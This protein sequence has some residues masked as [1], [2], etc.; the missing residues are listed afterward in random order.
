MYHTVCVIR[1]M[2]K[3]ILHCVPLN[4]AQE[5]KRISQKIVIVLAWQ[6]ARVS[7]SCRDSEVLQFLTSV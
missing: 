7:I 3:E 5:L 2:S 1:E 4:P 6:S